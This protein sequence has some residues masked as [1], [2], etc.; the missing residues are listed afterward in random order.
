MAELLLDFLFKLAAY[1]APFVVRRFYSAQKLSEQ[2]KIRVRGEG[3]GIVFSCGELPSVR[4]WLRITNLSPVDVEFDRIFGRV[5]H[6]SQLG[7]FQDLE[8]RQV[9]TSSEL[10][11]FI[12]APLSGEHVAF[13][14]KNRN[15]RH[16]FNTSL[17]LSGYIRSRLHNYQLPYREVQTGNVEFQNCDPLPPS[18]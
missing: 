1:T 9:P 18:P 13:L 2:I 8:H 4:I 17:A 7:E 16:T 14:R 3:Q 6:I 11:V 12:D 5:K 10:E 15:Q